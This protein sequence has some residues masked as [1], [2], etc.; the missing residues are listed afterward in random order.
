MHQNKFIYK[1]GN[2]YNLFFQN[3]LYRKLS[4]ISKPTIFLNLKT[5]LLRD[6]LDI[7]GVEHII[8]KLIRQT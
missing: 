1:L 4:E 8:S 6:I 5:N 3:T 2:Y 7:R